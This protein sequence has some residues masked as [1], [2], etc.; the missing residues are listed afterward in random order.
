MDYKQEVHGHMHGYKF[1]VMIGLKIMKAGH[2]K[3][4]EFLLGNY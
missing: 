2:E 4:E 3:I 1:T